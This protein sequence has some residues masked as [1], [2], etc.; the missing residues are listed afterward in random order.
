MCALLEVFPLLNVRFP[1]LRER[2]KERERERERAQEIKLMNKHSNKQKKEREKVN[3]TWKEARDK[4]LG[5]G[6]MQRKKERVC[7]I[8][9]EGDI[10][11]GSP[12]RKDFEVCGQN[13]NIFFV[14]FLL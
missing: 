1:K 3:D 5:E 4:K 13:G 8:E 11:F 14:D 2:K 6:R 12:F 7:K 9:R 10:V